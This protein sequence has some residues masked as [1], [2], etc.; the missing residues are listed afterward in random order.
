VEYELTEFGRTLCPAMMTLV[1]WAMKFPRTR[2]MFDRNRRKRS[3]PPN[4]TSAIRTSIPL[5]R[6]KVKQ[7]FAAKE[8]GGVDILAVWSKKGKGNLLAGAACRK[9][10]PSQLGGLKFQTV[11]ADS[12]AFDFRFKRLSR[13]PESYSGA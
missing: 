6:P 7:E 9:R 5:S 11:L 12:Q 8:R 3:Q 2:E 4:P 13:N 10:L 1:D